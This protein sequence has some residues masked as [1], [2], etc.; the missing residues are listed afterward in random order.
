MATPK[1]IQPRMNLN[2]RKKVESEYFIEI[3]KMIRVHSWLNPFQLL[4]FSLCACGIGLNSGADFRPR[5]RHILGPRGLKSAPLF[6][7][8]YTAGRSQRV[9]EWRKPPVCATRAGQLSENNCRRSG[10][11]CKAGA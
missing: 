4:T 3:K 6:S 10:N 11:H 2:G 1:E 7:R 5:L 8:S 9:K